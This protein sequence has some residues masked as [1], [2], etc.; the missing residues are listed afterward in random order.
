MEAIQNI[1]AI[2]LS[3][4]TERILV[5]RVSLLGVTFL[6][7]LYKWRMIMMLLSDKDSHG[8]MPEILSAILLG[9]NVVPNGVQGWFS[10]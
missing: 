2:F 4:R 3:L 8:M 5:P 1:S 7:T 6:R 10:G 9:K